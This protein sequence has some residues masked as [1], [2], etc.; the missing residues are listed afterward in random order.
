MVSAELLRRYPFFAG[1]SHERIVDLSKIADELSVDEGYNFFHEED[2]L[3]RF[4]LVLEGAVAIVF[5]LPERDVK[6]KISEQFAREMKT[7]DV[8]VSTVGTGDVFG[9]SGLVPPHKATAGA[10]SLTACRVVALECGKLRDLFEEDY[11]FGFLMTRRAAQVMRDRLRDLRIES[12][13][14]IT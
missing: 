2:E 9:W 7:I 14:F 13:A 12:L 3:D 8:T 10:K 4:Y 6:H 5:E 1:L 11:Q